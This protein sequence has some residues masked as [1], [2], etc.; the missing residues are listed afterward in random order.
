MHGIWERFG[1]FRGA[2]GENK[3]F[4]SWGAFVKL[5]NVY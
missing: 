5:H 4:C 3:R 1:E 2:N